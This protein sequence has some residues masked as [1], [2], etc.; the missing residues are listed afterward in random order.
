MNTIENKWAFIG[1]LL[2]ILCI[3][4]ILVI[5][6]GVLV[7]IF[8]LSLSYNHSTGTSLPLLFSGLFSV[9][10][11]IG[12]LLYVIPWVSKLKKSGEPMQANGIIVGAVVTALLNVGFFIPSA[13]NSLPSMMIYIIFPI[14]I[15]LLIAIPVFMHRKTKQD[16]DKQDDD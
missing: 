12:Q 10:I 8:G 14:L 2:L 3:N 7:V 11:G 6:F 9:M 5:C 1:G 16:N 15:A 4:F 13:A